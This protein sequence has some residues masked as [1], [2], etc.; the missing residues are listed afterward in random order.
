MATTVSMPQLGE[1]VTEGT[2]L[3]WAKQVGDTISA[4]EVLVEISTDKVDTEVPSPASGVVLEILV[5]EGDT[6][7]VGTALALIGEASDATGGYPSPE[8]EPAKA[9]APAESAAQPAPDSAAATAAEPAA[10]APAPEPQPAAQPAASA[11]AA[12]V[13]MPQLGETVTEGTILRWA[14]QVGDT[15]SAD[16]VLVEISTDKV[17][18]E[19]PSPASGVVLEILV[20]EGDTVAVGTALALIGEASGSTGAAPQPAPPAP[21]TAPQP[22]SEPAP[23]EAGPTPPFRGRASRRPR[24]RR[25]PNPRPPPPPH[26]GKDPLLGAV[27]CRR[28]SADSFART[29][30]TSIAS[31][32]PARVVASPGRTSSP[33]SLP[34][35]PH[36]R[37]RHRQLRLPPPRPPSLHRPRRRL[38]LPPLLPPSR[39]RQPLP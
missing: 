36:R 3:R 20:A 21:E 19:V 17:D 30:S 8:P 9:P 6:V 26:Q 22:A 39:L 25:Q 24:R 31:P 15:I 13:T 35:L 29:A 34:P 27:C 12:T 16:E 32:E 14:K 2:I 5:A 10:P 7:A 4:D 28:L 18:T 11:P 1:T 33:S 38:L 23:Q 37:P